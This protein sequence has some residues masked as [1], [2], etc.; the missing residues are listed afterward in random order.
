MARKRLFK[1]DRDLLL[2]IYKEQ[3]KLSA[4]LMRSALHRNIRREIF[5]LTNKEGVSL[6]VAISKVLDGNQEE[7]NTLLHEK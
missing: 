1:K 7:F 6:E 3:L 5:S 2:H 4:C